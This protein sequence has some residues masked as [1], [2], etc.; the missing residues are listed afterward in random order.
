[1]LGAG[2][3]CYVRAARDPP[4][5]VREARYLR[6]RGHGRSALLL[7]AKDGDALEAEVVEVPSSSV[8]SS[9]GP[10]AIWRLPGDVDYRGHLLAESGSELATADEGAAPVVAG[11]A[12]DVSTTLLA[13]AGAMKQLQVEVR[14]MKKERVVVQ[15]VPK[16]KS[17]PGFP[18]ALEKLAASYGGGDLDDED[19]E[20]TEL[21]DDGEEES[22]AGLTARMMGSS[23][24][25]PGRKIKRKANPASVPA[26]SNASPQPGVC[27]G[28]PLGS[29]DPE[30]GTALRE[31]VEAQKSTSKAVKRLAK[32]R[33]H[34]DSSD[35]SSSDGDHGKF[36]EP[37]RLR[38][39]IREKP[40]QYID[41]WSTEV[42]T[43]CRAYRPGANWSFGLHSEGCRKS[44]GP[45]SGLL[46][47]HHHL[48]A[49]LDVALL[50]R[51]PVVAIAMVVGLSQGVHQAA[52]DGG[53]WRLASQLIV[54]PDPLAPQTF[55]G[56][57]SRLNRLM[58]YT[59]NV[60]KLQ[61]RWRGKGRLGLDKTS[62]EEG[63]TGG[64]D[65]GKGDG[66]KG[67]K[68]KEE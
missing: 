39:E 59:E 27:S 33:S 44:F 53:K 5:V 54:S 6:S 29:L 50:E 16:T 56:L 21:F 14:D 2:D 8:R 55:A 52:M 13:L 31:M 18:E 3:V 25:S 7:A 24:P 34:G 1:M 10:G 12:A 36:S 45:N 66:K 32:K 30:L 43:Q 23:A 9:S 68:G 48:A 37:K 4:A 60:E 49:I 38:K 57:P 61:T 47:V 64:G 51:K 40:E 63:K 65:G 19:E 22:P 62:G 26:G 67:K 20:G 28:N 11:S 15:Q 35:D 41:T 17:G 58:T 42:A 46:R